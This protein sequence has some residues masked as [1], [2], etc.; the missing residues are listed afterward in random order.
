LLCRSS[1]Q[2]LQTAVASSCCAQPDLQFEHPSG[3]QVCV[4]GVEHLEQQ[5]HIGKAEMLL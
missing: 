5:P 1:L 3:V 4:F 2:E